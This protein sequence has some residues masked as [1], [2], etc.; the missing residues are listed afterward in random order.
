MEWKVC[1]CGKGA[2]AFPKKVNYIPANRKNK[3]TGKGGMPADLLEFLSLLFLSY[4]V[5][6]CI[7]ASTFEGWGHLR[8][9]FT[10]H[11]D[12]WSDR[13][14]LGQEDLNHGR[15]SHLWYQRNWRICLF[16]FLRQPKQP[17]IT[18]TFVI[19]AE[20]NS[21]LIL[22]AAATNSLSSYRYWRVINIHF[23]W[24][25]VRATD[26]YMNKWALNTTTVITD[27]E[28]APGGIIASGSGLQIWLVEGHHPNPY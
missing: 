28:H 19:W 27:W 13:T 25:W 5:Q 4:L 8:A 17:L 21:G 12:T 3:G 15:N 10:A 6:F 9:E 11:Y 20:V 1:L 2:Q 14:A 26:L 24:P 7:T 22:V 18:T 23:N 16:L